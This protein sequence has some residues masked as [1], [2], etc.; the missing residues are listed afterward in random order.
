MY[1]VTSVLTT[2]DVRTSRLLRRDISPPS[3]AVRTR[4]RWSA[5]TTSAV[6]SWGH[7]ARP[8]GPALHAGR[9]H[10]RQC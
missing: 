1:E 6:A 7:I 2:S 10:T 3:A 8:S 5:P 9:C 4:Q